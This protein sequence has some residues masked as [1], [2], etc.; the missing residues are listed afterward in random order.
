MKKNQIILAVLATSLL[1]G[2]PM[3][4]QEQS[5]LIERANKQYKEFTGVFKCAW[6]K[7]YRACD[8]AQKRK[9]KQAGVVLAAIVGALGY[10]FILLKKKEKK[11]VSFRESTGKEG[12]A[13][14]APLPKFAPTQVRLKRVGVQDPEKLSRYRQRGEGQVVFQRL[15]QEVTDRWLR[16]ELSDDVYERYA[17]VLDAYQKRDDRYKISSDFQELEKDIL[18]SG[19]SDAVL[20]KKIKDFED[21]LDL[22]AKA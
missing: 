16:G 7:G 20:I 2:H 12:D 19:T 3:V 21:K 15:G 22:P 10:G 17:E 14:E 4:A 6:K 5:G 1:L 9:I 11:K 18:K 13:P 8:P